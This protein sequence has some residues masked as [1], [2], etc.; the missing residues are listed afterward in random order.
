VD[1]PKWIAQLSSARS[2]EQ[3][4]AIVN[5]YIASRDPRELAS[6]P[7]ECAVRP[8]AAPEEV[9]GCAYRLAASQAHDD[10]A[11]VIQRMGAFFARA[12]VRLAELGRA[13]DRRPG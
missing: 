13:P 4:L 8:M 10:N 6:L 7:A 5:A 2:A 3:V 12:S 9:T 1:T 11:R